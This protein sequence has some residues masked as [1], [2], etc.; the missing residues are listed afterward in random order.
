MPPRV[1]VGGA[2][3]RVRRDAGPGVDRVGVLAPR[4][5]PHLQKGAAHIGVTHAPGL[6][7]VPG[8]GGAPGAAP[9]L[10]VGHVRRSLGVVGRLG[11]P[12]DDAV[13]HV[14]HPG[15]GARAVDAVGGAHLAVVAPAVAV[16]LLG[17]A[18]ALAHDDAAVVAGLAGSQVADPTE[19]RSGGLATFSRWHRAVSRRLCLLRHASRPPQWPRA[20]LVNSRA[21]KSMTWAD[22]GGV[23]FGQACPPSTNY[24]VGFTTRREN[25]KS[26]SRTSPGRPAR[27]QAAILSMLSDGSPSGAPARRLTA[28][29]PS[30]S[31]PSP[32]LDTSRCAPQS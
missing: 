3:L 21:L 28:E 1:F 13:P 24:G 29:A 11:L 8:E 25:R 30:D 7:G 5:A 2:L 14:D 32:A 15:A 16:E 4:L 10:H 27:R 9:G 19:Q 6:V 31:R 18:V 17:A 23:D 26:G 12:G 20:H 22:G